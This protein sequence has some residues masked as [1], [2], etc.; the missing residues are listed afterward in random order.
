[1]KI[2]NYKIKLCHIPRQ[3]LRI[4]CSILASG[5]IFL[6]LGIQGLFNMSNDNNLGIPNIELFSYLSL[7]MGIIMILTSLTS[8]QVDTGYEN[9]INSNNQNLLNPNYQNI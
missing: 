3:S 6:F 9:L 5:I 4:K 1:M 8:C 7:C 2:G